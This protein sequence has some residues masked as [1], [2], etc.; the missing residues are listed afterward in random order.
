MFCV[1]QTG[2]S[3]QSLPP[4]VPHSPPVRATVAYNLLRLLLGRVRSAQGNNR[5]FRQ[6][7]NSSGGLEVTVFA[8]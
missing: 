2:N 8:S 1:Y 5:V 6:H 3:W 7:T 4:G